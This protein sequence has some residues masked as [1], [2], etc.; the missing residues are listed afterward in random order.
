MTD[1]NRVQRLRAKGYDW[2][3]VA[4]DPKV[5]FTPAEG[6]GDPGRALKA[7]YLARKSH[8]SRR[9]RGRYGRMPIPGNASPRNEDR[10]H[11][12]LTRGT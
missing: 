12:R 4:E 10:Q 3:S 1:W 6:I 7:L 9:P 5:G 2:T 8:S 11:P